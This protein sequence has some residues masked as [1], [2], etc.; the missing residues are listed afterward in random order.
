MQTLASDT[1]FSEFYGSKEIAKHVRDD[2][3]AAGGLGQL[4]SAC[5][6]GLVELEVTWAI[7]NEAEGHIGIW[8]RARK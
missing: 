1:W 3:H 4:W 7:C 8:D 6:R 2:I 5:H